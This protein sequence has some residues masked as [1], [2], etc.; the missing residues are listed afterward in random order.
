MTLEPASFEW[1]PERLHSIN[2]LGRNLDYSIE[3]IRFVHEMVLESGSVNTTSVGEKLRVFAVESFGDDAKGVLQSWNI[4][5]SEDVGVI[6][7]GLVSE[8]LL[9]AEDDD[10]LDDLRLD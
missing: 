3:A 6:V 2:Y 5:R 10:S 9:V 1:S 7:E 8:G 4:V